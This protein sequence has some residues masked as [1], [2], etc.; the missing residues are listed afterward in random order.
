MTNLEPA[1]RR[2]ALVWGAAALV[3]LAI[4]LLPVPWCPWALIA[5][6]PCPGCGLTRATLAALRGDVHGAF[7]LHPAV[8]VVTPTVVVVLV[9]DLWG[10]TRRGVWGEGQRGGRVTTAFV[11]LVVATL[12]GVWLARFLGFFGGPVPIE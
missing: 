6:V 5:R 9:R 8:F 4:A 3:V 11:G 10:F 7:R 1:A 2:A 12:L